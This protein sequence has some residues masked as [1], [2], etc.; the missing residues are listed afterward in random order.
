VRR[1]KTFSD[2]PQ[3]G[4]VQ[5][6]IDPERAPCTG[7]SVCLPERP[8]PPLLAGEAEPL[9]LADQPRTSDWLIISPMA[10][11]IFRGPTYGL[12]EWATSMLLSIN[13]SPTLHGNTAA[14]RL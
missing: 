14:Q 5:I 8:D 9:D 1:G 3:T 10:T 6:P 12:R 11:T 13:T 4:G 2:L 7:G